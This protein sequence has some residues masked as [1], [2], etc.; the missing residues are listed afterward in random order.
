ML[1]P[2]TLLAGQLRRQLGFGDAPQA[3]Q[4]RRQVPQRAACAK[5]WWGDL[6]SAA[7][8]SVIVS[9]VV[10]AVR[11]SDTNSTSLIVYARSRR[12]VLPVVHHRH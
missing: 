10:M 5:M 11:N 4:L 1:S 6:H 7:L 8:G 2:G 9:S 12:W 3:G